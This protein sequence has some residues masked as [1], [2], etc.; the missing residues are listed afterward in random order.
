VHTITLQNLLVT[1]LSMFLTAVQEERGPYLREEQL[2]FRRAKSS[3]TGHRSQA[4]QLNSVPGTPGMSYPFQRPFYV[5]THRL[6][7]VDANNQLV[8]AASLVMEM[9]AKAEKVESKSIPDTSSSTD[10]TVPRNFRKSLLSVLAWAKQIPM[11]TQLSVED[12][13]ELINA[14]W[15]EVNTLKFLF[16][17][18]NNGFTSQ[19]DDLAHIYLID[20]QQGTTCYDEEAI[21]ESVSTMKDIQLD[22]SELSHLK[23]ITLMN[24]CKFM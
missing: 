12:Q 5:P 6:H 13:I 9:L 20:D 11:F 7:K 8:V 18:A 15:I 22:E 3:A 4:T 24:P 1:S 10:K 16:H 14:T 21:K 19:T 17:V 2:P 23:L